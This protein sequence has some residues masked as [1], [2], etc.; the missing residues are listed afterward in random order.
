M[1]TNTRD[2]AVELRHG[3]R[4]FCEKHITPFAND[5]DREQAIPSSLIEKMAAMG[6]L[7]ATVPTTYG[8]MGWNQQTAAVLFEEIGKAC[9]SVRSILTVHLSLVT[10]TIYRWGTHEQKN[11]WLPDLA[12]GKKIAA[13]ALTEPET[14]SDAKSISSS[15]T[16]KDNQ[17]ILNGTKKWITFGQRA[18]C[19]L[20]FA[21]D[22]DGISAFLLEKDN[23]GLSVKPISDMMGTRA[24]LLAELRLTDCVVSANCLLGKRGWGFT[25]VVNTALDNGR[26]SVTTGTLGLAK[27][28]LEQ[29]ITF[30]CYRKQFGTLLKEH[31]LIKQKIAA[32]TANVKAASLLC[33]DAAEERD[34]ASPNA[35]IKTVVA[36]YFTTKIASEAAADALQ[37]HGALGF[38][39]SSNVQRFYRDARVM[40]VIEG[41]TELQQIV[42]SD[43]AVNDLDSIINGNL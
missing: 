14:G 33:K 31:Q 38:H 22:V 13:F 5:F 27:A 3:F 17:Y 16:D 34:Q 2:L 9:S 4:Q 19:F 25:Q 11:R 10:E 15:F 12:S 39:G 6:Y 35:I 1:E 41:S 8:G 30:V 7:G 29:S 20:V 21:R 40:E 24:S 36:K 43:H 32:M 26:F 28:C 18:D 23:P 42:I 37:I